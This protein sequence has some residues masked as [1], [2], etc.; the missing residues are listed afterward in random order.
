MSGV[1]YVAE[2]PALENH[3][4]LRT[5]WAEREDWV[6][7]YN[8]IFFRHKQDVSLKEE[9]QHPEASGSTTT[10]YAWSPKFPISTG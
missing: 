5:F 9:D 1:L 7:R 3:D 2:D 10:L 6:C 8:G 4:N